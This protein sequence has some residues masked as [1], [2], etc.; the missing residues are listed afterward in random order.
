M[1]SVGRAVRLFVVMCGS[2]LLLAACG[3]DDDEEETPTATSAPV[4]TAT[5]T[6]AAS[7]IASPATMVASPATSPV[8][9][10]PVAS[11]AIG[12]AS[13]SP[14]AAS[15]ATVIL[16]DYRISLFQSS[17]TVGQPYTFVV[18]NNGSET[19]ELVIE[20]KGAVDQP[21][22]ADGRR[23]EIVEVPGGGMAT[24]TWTFDEPGEYQLACH[25]DGHYERGM[26]QEAIVVN[27]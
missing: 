8:S 27:P 3:G 19:H 25:R 6:T 1:M 15:G 7:P 2:V 21:L 18:E 23:A 5:A 14:V 16:T 26:V 22:E 24:L 4:S 13:G 17:F 12:G 10:T 9:S 11:P 20:A